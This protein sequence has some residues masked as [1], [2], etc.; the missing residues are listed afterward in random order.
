MIRKRNTVEAAAEAAN[1]LL[2][3][4]LA[5]RSL[6]LSL[7]L[8][9]H[10]ASAP[11]AVLVRWCG[12]F[13]VGP[14]AARVALSRMVDRGELTA[15]DGHYALAGRLAERQADQDRALAPALRAWDG[16]WLMAVVDDGRR[17]PA[18]RVALREALRRSRLVPWRESVWVRPD[19]FG[20]VP[21]TAADRTVI[22]GQ[23]TWWRA[24]PE[25]PIDVAAAYGLADLL[26]RG[27]RLTDLIAT[28]TEALHQSGPAIAEA[29]APAFVVGAATAQHLRRDPL[30]PSELLPPG[31][32]ADDL[33]RQYAEFSA[34][35]DRSIAGW[36][37]A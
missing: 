32:P 9:R 28:A 4:P 34:A 21:A 18:D 20:E 16:G 33:R 27:R 10:P 5:A 12:L 26:D 36:I 1:E 13:G 15:A 17:S 8:G 7:L 6:V 35:M 19:N 24:R 2:E 3:R 25:Q 29:L 31:W 22:D 14:T 37:S 23:C 11:V 30:L